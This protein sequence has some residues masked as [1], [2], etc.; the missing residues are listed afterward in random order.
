MR[1][2]AE[3]CLGT[4]HIARVPTTITYAL[5]SRDALFLMASKIQAI[6]G[7]WEGANEWFSKVTKMELDVSFPLVVLALQRFGRVNTEHY[8]L[9]TKPL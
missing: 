7:G 4:I 2:G 1:E 9:P 5:L 6:G 8:Q 3:V